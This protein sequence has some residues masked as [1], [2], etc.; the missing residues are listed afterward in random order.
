M[1]KMLTLGLVLA[2]S[3]SQAY[4]STTGSLLLQGI[5][6]KKVSIE[7]TAEGAASA[8]DL[9]QTQSD[10]KVA[11]V[12]EISNSKSGYKVKLTSANQGNLKRTDGPEVFGYSLKYGGQAVALGTVDGTTFASPTAAA[13]NVEKDLQVSYTGVAAELMVEG[14]YADTVTL[15]ISAN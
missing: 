15:N 12:R 3:A 4:S 14:T 2:F 6:A 10:L 1:K 5:V 9:E 8:L 13:V 7:V 11:S